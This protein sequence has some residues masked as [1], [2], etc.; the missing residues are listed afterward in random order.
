MTRELERSRDTLVQVERELA[1]KEMAR[2][3]A[4]EIKNP[5]TPMKLSIQH[6]RRAYLD[7]A[8]NFGEILEQV[9]QTVIG[10]IEALSRIAS[11]FSAFARM[12][13]RA[14]AICAPGEVVGEAVQLFRQDSGVEFVLTVEPGL[15]DIMADREE[16]RRACINIL[17]N[18]VQAMGETGRMEITVSRSPRGVQIAFRDSGHGIPDD[19]KPKLFQPNFSTKTDGMGLGLAIVKKTVDDLGGTVSIQSTVGEG[20]TVILDIPVEQAQP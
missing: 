13:R 5:L 20:T 11:E 18:G 3:V 2:Q 9:T 19:V 4:H 8:G 16:F 1:W 15:P 7:H 14:L 10:Q 17:R 12:P 6:L